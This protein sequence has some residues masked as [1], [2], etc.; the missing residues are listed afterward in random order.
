M[1]KIRQNLPELKEFIE[2][3]TG[4]R[5]R[6]RWTHLWSNSDFHCDD[7]SLRCGPSLAAF[8]VPGT[9]NVTFCNESQSNFINQMLRTYE[10]ID[11]QATCMSAL[12]AH[13][14]VH[15]AF[16]F[17]GK[18]DDVGSATAHFWVSHIGGN[19]HLRN[20]EYCGF[21]EE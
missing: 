15:N 5:M 9:N 7:R 12:I 16:G 18:A 2:R 17:E 6:N 20:P 14:F 13:E 8:A 4:H 11:D 21:V 3:E 10:D 19:R 1:Q